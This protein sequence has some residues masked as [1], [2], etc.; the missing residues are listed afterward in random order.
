MS[1]KTARKAWLS[2]MGLGVGIWGSGAGRGEDPRPLAPTP[3]TEVV[4]A[5]VVE[6]KKQEPKT[7][8][9]QLPGTAAGSNQNDIPLPTARERPSSEGPPV[10][11]ASVP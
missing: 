3:P 6:P 10:G 4:R 2:T 8:Q 9:T 7:E 5:Q 11:N 1:R